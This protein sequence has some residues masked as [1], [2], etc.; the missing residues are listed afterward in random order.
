MKVLVLNAGSSSI[1]YRLFDMRHQRA[2][3]SGLIE[4]IGEDQSRLVH[5]VHDPATK[6]ERI[7]AV[8]DHQAGM[9][10]MTGV[11]RESGAVQDIAGLHAIGHRVVH[12]GPDFKES[13][14]IDD[15]VMDVIRQYAPMAPLH[16]PPSI[17]C[18]E[19]S[20][21]TYPDVPQVAVFDTAFHHFIP[22]YAYRYAI[23]GQFYER[24]HVRRYGF[25]GTS[26]RYVA[27]RAAEYL[28]RPPDAVNLIV[29]HLGNGSSAAAIRSGRC[30]DTSMGMTP[31]EG[32][33]MGTRCGD[34][35]P[36]VIFH[37]A[38]VTGKPNQEIESILNRQSG[39]KGICG[40]NDLRE[41]LRLAESGDN[42]AALA[43]DMYSYRIRKYIGAYCAVLGRVD[44]VVFTAGIGEN[45]AEIRDRACQGLAGLGIQLDT[46][47]N[48][49]ARGTQVEIQSDESP[50]K[51]LV[52]PTDEELE[53]AQETIEAIQSSGIGAASGKQR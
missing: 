20:L 40:E 47:R 53:I 21:A 12:G 31:L 33:M 52:I 11:L 44:A 13:T 50:V 15:H 19:S 18:I 7:H 10:L 1:K 17:I 30:V 49:A 28:H 4:R 35:D 32:L 39:L 2:L 23:P 46:G 48:T 36:A 16:N 6:I 25:H 5:Q 14:L 27:K 38:T 51:V 41:V 26:Y 24:Y 22:P 3:A 45:A 9:D 29:L 42:R 34:I 43:I 37:L 8:P